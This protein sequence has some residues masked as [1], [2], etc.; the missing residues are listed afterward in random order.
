MIE[1]PTT[2]EEAH[3]QLRR[4]NEEK[5]RRLE[6]EKYRFYEPSGKGEEFIRKVGGN[7]V[8]I[9][10]YS[11]ANGVGK[12]A[13][14]ANIV[15]NLCYETNN[16]FFSDELFQ[17]FPYPKRGRIVSDSTNIVENLIPA[18]KEWLPADNRYTTRKAMKQ[19]ESKWK[20]DTGFSFN[21]MTY[22]QEPKEFEGATLGWAW[23]D[24]PPPE[25]ILKAT[26]SRM[27]LGG[28]IFITDTPLAGS[29]YLYDMLA[30]GSIEV[31][32]TTQS[33]GAAEKVTRKIAYVEADVESA[34]RTH[35]IRGHLDHATILQMT[36]EY[37]EDEKQARIYGKFQ[38]L[39]GMVFKQFSRTVHVIDPFEITPSQF[40]VYEAIDP[41]PR[42][43]DAV[44]WLAIDR[45]GNK[46]VVDE[47]WVGE[48]LTR[49]LAQRI[50]N[51]A[52]NYRIIRRIGDPSMF[53]EDKHT[54]KSLSSRLSSYGIS[55]LEA[56][57]ARAASDKRIQDALG[58]TQIHDEMVKAPELYVFSTCERTIFEIEHY[59]WDEWVGRTADR[60]NK[61][62]KPVD[63]DDH[64]IENLGRLLFQ[65]PIWVPA[66]PQ[67]AHIIQ[68]STRHH[69]DPY[70]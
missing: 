6:Q 43:P 54:G 12:T 39:A 50:K 34:C 26:I 24:E 67:E 42:T 21:I 25:A 55:Y 53:I 10:M 16:P 17:N 35:G 44:M 56:T 15:A 51:K 23:F 14:G 29:A 48:I 1:T 46:Y 62:E 47:L 36:A 38:H 40:A 69:N 70:A 45:Q 68:D 60:K 41:H 66:P 13:T 28:I 20:T 27:R 4:L 32:V 57:K 18:L 19:Y 58:Y 7:E 11:A 64:M 2:K 5:L 30:K 52:S 31:E 61:K 9:A 33:G 3:E 65:E 49:D 59:R 63:K 8:F 37:S 22:D